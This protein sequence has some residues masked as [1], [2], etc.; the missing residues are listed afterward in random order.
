MWP[1][2]RRLPPGTGG[3]P[4]VW[5]KWSPGGEPRAGAGALRRWPPPVRTRQGEG[6]RQL[7]S[8]TDDKKEHS[9]RRRLVVCLACATPLEDS[10]APLGSLR[11]RGCRSADRRLDQELVREWLASGAPLD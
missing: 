5:G 3:S 4:A 10:L 2:G 9:H 8:P 1:G 6:L 11:C 7:A